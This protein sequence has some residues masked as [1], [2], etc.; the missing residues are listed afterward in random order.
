MEE[1]IKLLKKIVNSNT[2]AGHIAAGQGMTG[3]RKVRGPCR[4]SGLTGKGKCR[5]RK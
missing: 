4:Q 1:N 5:G 2:I 3:T